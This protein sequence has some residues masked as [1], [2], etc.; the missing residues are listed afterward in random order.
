ML[1]RIPADVSKRLALP[2]PLL[3]RLLVVGLLL[4]ACGAPPAGEVDLGSGRRFIPQI[5][6]SIDNVGLQAAVAL[7]ADGVP[8]VTYLG[9]PAVLAEGEIAVT[10]PVGAPFVPGV[11]LASQTKGVWNRGAVAMYQDPPDRVSVPFGPATVASLSEATALNMN[12]TDVA[13]GADGTV[14]AVWA[15]RDGIWYAS[16]SDS[17]TAEQ[18]TKQLPSVSRAGA[19]GWPS[20][21]VDEAGT[22]WIAA[23]TSDA[24]GQHVIAATPTGDTWDVQVVADIAAGC[25]D[26]SDAGRTGIAV[27]PDGPV[28]VYADPQSGVMAARQHGRGWTTETV[29]SGADG[30]GISLSATSDG[31]LTASYYASRQSVSLATSDGGSWSTTEAAAIEPTSPSP[32]VGPSPS[33]SAPA[34]PSAS[35]SASPSASGSASPTAAPTPTLAPPANP[36]AAAERATDSRST[37][38]AVTDDGTVYL[39]YVD[40]GADAVVLASSPDGADFAPIETSGTEGGRWPDISVTPDGATVSLAWYAPGQQDLAVGIYADV[41][42]LEVAAPSPPFAVGT[43]TGGSTTECS[44]DTTEVSPDLEVEAPSGAVARGFLQTCLVAPADE[45]LTLTFDNQDPGQSHNAHFYTAAPPDGTDLFQSGLPTPG[46]ETQKNPD[47]DPQDPGTYY[48][49][50]DVHP[51]MNGSLV[52]VKAKK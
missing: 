43:T 37:G 51:T 25:A 23:T 27:T 29:E 50:C 8:F 47:I 18:V 32:S 34:S 41:T 21:A 48:Y 40:P 19:I 1:A 28:I 31:A 16:G 45:K 36:V 33:P 44:A 26:C 35:G 13:V 15:G 42:G 5:V 46:P 22:P 14:H 39:T 2:T 4:A 30:T 49:Q 3:G 17:F 52:V 10:R 24:A 6:D 38:V 11:L 9:F 12:G 20:I 7:D